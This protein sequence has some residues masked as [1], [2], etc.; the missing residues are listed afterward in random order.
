[1]SSDSLR[2]PLD[3]LSIELTRISAEIQSINSGFQAQ[4]EQALAEARATIETQYEAKFKKKID[5]V[6]EEI[7][8]EVTIE[9][10]KHFEAELK[11]RISRL[12]AVQ[13]E[14]AK[15][16]AQLEGVAREIAA[17][18]DD[19]SVELSKVMRKR[20]EQAELKAYLSGLS[21]S[22]GEKSKSKTANSGTDV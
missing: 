15:V 5:E 6:R 9:L 21:Y 12:E 8:Q 18:L 16:T 22:I 4:M 13:T 1:M 2:E 3:S 11:A 14:M 19:P 7:R 10:E 20:S 17:M